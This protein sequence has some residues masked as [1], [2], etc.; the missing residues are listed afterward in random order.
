MR[1]TSVDPIILRGEQEYLA[2]QG[3]AEA[4]D[5]G[6]WQLLVKVST[7]EHTAGASVIPVYPEANW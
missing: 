2:T 3:S 5:N 7:D 1:I 6:D 4:V